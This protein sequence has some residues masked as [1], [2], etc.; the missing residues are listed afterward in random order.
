[1]TNEEKITK[2]SNMWYHCL[3]DH[4]KDRDCHFNIVKRWSYGKPPVYSVEH[5]GYIYE[6][7]NDEFDTMK[8]AEEYLIEQLI[9]IVLI[10]AKRW[11]EIA[12]NEK[13]NWDYEIANKYKPRFEKMIEDINEFN[14]S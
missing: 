8:E 10:E 14:I 1:M 9:I 11:I 12:N 5:Y 7:I 6:E 13:E 2:L 4:H 3:I